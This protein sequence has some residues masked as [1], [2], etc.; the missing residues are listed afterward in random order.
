MI[1]HPQKL[2]NCGSVH[3]ARHY[4][5][6]TDL[7]PTTSATSPPPSRKHKAPEFDIADVDE[8]IGSDLGPS[9]D[10]WADLYKT[11]NAKAA[12]QK[13][14]AQD[15]EE[16]AAIE[17]L[18]SFAEEM[19]EGSTFEQ[20]LK[21]PRTTLNAKLPARIP[22]RPV[23]KS[24]MQ[25]KPTS[26]VNASKTISQQTFEE[27]RVYHREQQYRIDYTWHGEPNLSEPAQ[28]HHKSLL[29]RYDWRLRNPWRTPNQE[30]KHQ[31]ALANI[32]LNENV[33]HSETQLPGLDKYQEKYLEYIRL[34]RDHAE[35]ET[36]TRLRRTAGRL[37]PGAA[38]ARGKPVES[39]SGLKAALHETRGPTKSRNSTPGQ[40]YHFALPLRGDL[41][42]N[43]FHKGAMVF[44]WECHFDSFLHEWVVPDL[45][46][47]DL[48][49]QELYMEAGKGFVEKDWANRIDI[50]SE[51][52]AP[53]PGAFYRSVRR[54]NRLA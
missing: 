47:P 7:P 36:L 49:A 27:F 39:I 42:T 35:Q 52:W 3:Q 19:A 9:D 37:L 40:T 29:S 41:P 32:Y 16:I 30:Q 14:A 22:L 53:K 13:N 20:P 6:H 10:P 46:D 15:L 50:R 11:V 21:A 51:T 1:S 48:T 26:L 4:A 24:L 2:L 25:V 17:A 28:P 54:S 45:K 12:H 33:A 18:L 44:I 31:Y 8:A 38:G 34:E 5:T 43:A 23:R